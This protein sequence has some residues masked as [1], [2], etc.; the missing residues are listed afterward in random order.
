M[1]PPESTT[2]SSWQ[3]R[4]GEKKRRQEAVEA[5]VQDLGTS[6]Y[7]SLSYQ[8]DAISNLIATLLN[9][10]HISLIQLATINFKQL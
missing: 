9:Y 2:L 8:S 1:N 4:Q 6:F 10:V 3:I 7:N 5:L